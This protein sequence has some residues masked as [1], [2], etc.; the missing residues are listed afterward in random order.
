MIFLA[1]DLEEYFDNRGFY[2]DYQEFAPGPVVRNST[3]LAAAVRSIEGR[4]E[5]AREKAA[6]EIHVFL[7]RTCHG[8]NLAGDCKAGRRISRI[9]CERMKFRKR[10]L[11]QVRKHGESAENKTGVK[12]MPEKIYIACGI[13]ALLS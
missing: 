2:Y 1:Y 12:G 8:E 4:Q 6:A 7:R 13:P 3:E 9:S 10:R 5:E 11:R